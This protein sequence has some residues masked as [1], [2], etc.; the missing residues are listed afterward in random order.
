VELALFCTLSTRTKRNVMHPD[1]TFPAFAPVAF[2]EIKWKTSL[3]GVQCKM[4]R[5]RETKKREKERR[6]IACRRRDS[7]AR[8]E[9]YSRTSYSSVFHVRFH[10]ASRQYQTRAHHR[11]SLS[12]SVRVSLLSRLSPLPL[13]PIPLIRIPLFISLSC[14]SFQRSPSLSRFLFLSRA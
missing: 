10:L 7:E 12:P 9:R 8:R 3:S 6:S 1:I 2:F 5:E 4:E 13:F 14:S 11:I